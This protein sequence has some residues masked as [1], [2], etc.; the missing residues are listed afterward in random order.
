M[1]WMRRLLFLSVVS[2][3]VAMA[4]LF[5]KSP[6]MQL[7]TIQI[8]LDPKSK[9]AF[10]FDR[11]RSGLQASL[12]SYLGLPFWKIPLDQVLA[13][14][15]KDKRVSEAQIQREFPHHMRVLSRPERSRC[16]DTWMKKAISFRRPR[17][18]ANA[19]AGA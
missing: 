9:D 13:D 5:L 2:A 16:W 8:E 14:I 19:G 4:W 11:I 18:D 17:C 15:K 6:M 12:A 3:G 1:I 7:K 10:M